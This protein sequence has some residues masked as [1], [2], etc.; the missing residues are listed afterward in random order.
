MLVVAAVATL[1]VFPGSSSADS[2]PAAVLTSSPTP[3]T[4][5]APLTVTFDASGS[6]DSN[7]PIDLWTLDFG[8]GSS[9]SGTGPL[10]SNDSHTYAAGSYTATLTI[11]DDNDASDSATVAVTA[12]ANVPPTAVLTSTPTPATGKAPLNVTFNGSASSDSDGSIASWKLDFGDNSAVASG[13]GLPPSSLPHT[14][15]AGTYTA[16]LTVTDDNGATGSVSVSVKSNPNVPPTAVLTSTPTPATGKAPLNVTFNGSASSDSDGSIASWKLDFGDNSAVASGSGVPPS[17]LPHTYAAGTYTATL[18]VTDD[19]G[20]TGSVSVSVKSNPNVPPTAVLTSSP[21][22]ATGKAPLNVTFNGSASSDSDGSIASWKLDFGDSSTVASGSGVP[23]SSLPHTYAAG[24]YKAVLTVTD[25][26]GASDTDSVAVDANAP[27][28]AALTADK[29]SGPTPLT[30]KFDGSGSTDSDG[31]IV[32]W[33]L[34]FGD[35]NTATGTGA[36]PNAISHTYTSACSCTASLTVTDNQGAQSAA[37][38][39]GMHVTTNLPPVAT[40]TATPTSG[41]V[42]LAVSFDGS[43]SQDPDGSIASWSLDFGDGSTAATGTGAVPN[44][45]PYTY[46]AAGTYHAKLTVTDSSNASTTSTPVTITVNPQPSISVA[47]V[48]QNEGNSGTT[49]F[50]FPVTLSS[51]STH[52]VTVDYATAD[53]TATAGSDYTAT[54]GTLTIPA[55]MDC[56]SGHQTNPACQIPV[57]VTGDTLYENNETFTLDLSN[58][59][60]AT[61]ATT[62]ATATIVNDD[63]PPL[64]EAEAGATLEGDTGS[65]VNGA[66]SWSTGGS[67]QLNDASGFSEGVHTFSIATPG[68]P[69]VSGPYTYNGLSGD[70][71]TGVRPSGSVAVGQ[72]AFQPRF[73][74]IP[75]VLCDPVKT[76]DNSLA[77]CVP[78]TSGLATSVHYATSDGHSLTT[79]IPVIEGQDYVYA[80]GTLT[81]PAGAESGS[82]TFETIPNTTR[83]NPNPANPGDDLTRWF[84]VL[85]SSPTNATVEPGDSLG[86]ATIIEDDGLNPPT[87]TTGAASS[88]GVDHATV[89]A[90]VNPNGDATDV[91]VQYGP[92]DSYGSQTA[93]QQVAGTSAQALTF[94]LTGLSPGTTYH[95]Q[96]VAS[97]ADHS[98]GYGQDMTFTTDKAPNAVLAANV[99]SGPVS[100]PV[101]FDGADSSDPDGSIASWTLAFGDGASTGGSGSA[102]S[103]ITHTYTSACSCTASLI[104][105]DNQ[106]VQSAPATVVIEATKPGNPTK[107]PKLTTVDTEVLGPTSTRIVLPVDPNGSTTQVWIEYGKDTSYGTKS[108]AQRIPAGATKDLTFTLTG[109]SPQTL[110]HYRIEAWHTTD[111]GEAQ[112]QDLIFSTP[113]AKRMA[114]TLRARVVKATA[115]GIVLLPVSCGGNALSR[116]KGQ[117]LLEL[118][119]RAIG[120][121]SF[122]VPRAHRKLVSVRIKKTAL[123]RLL[124]GTGLHLTLTLSVRTGVDGVDLTTKRITV[125]PQKATT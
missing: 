100:L 19:N 82:V 24:T 23:P 17:S 64:L 20:A 89:A 36:V 47:N 28:T 10:P 102:P 63:Q 11:T 68:A 123:R 76:P 55:N 46:S 45:I 85:F 18:T 13:S 49:N 4:G 115:K 91:Y 80:A 83:E 109:L 93:T 7:A 3:A 1:I 97:H 29:T 117:A 95:Y 37:A 5:K 22:P 39:V 107:N 27:P 25:D 34:A 94:S 92:T 65:V 84:N 31:S 43:A 125:L 112:S 73:I 6:S 14:Y 21:S 62:S 90:T 120:S 12:N 57:P 103:A 124:A 44:A 58:A 98:T 108:A 104:V 35:G 50:N 9:D 8:D 101:T 52:A 60:G 26:N 87:A 105:T 99:T 38:T 69:S 53:V 41:T 30:V 116:C 70:T 61:L 81:I 110:Y 33:S 16:T 67:L 106:G 118:G 2:G 42:A 96:V 51:V 75:V 71:L 54:S 32:S 86:I 122:S 40:L 72:I 74:M 77:H 119:R 15:A 88:I 56:T 78:T 121:K 79:S 113:K 114:V 111:S 48:S 66:Q 59:T